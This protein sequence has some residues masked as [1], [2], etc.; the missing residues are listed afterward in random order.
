MQQPVAHALHVNRT[1][2]RPP[3][4][5]FVCRW[6][7]SKAWTQQQKQEQEDEKH[8]QKYLKN[9][10]RNLRKQRVSAIVKDQCLS[11]FIREHVSS[12]N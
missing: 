12:R 4:T 3:N 10:R 7:L 2:L 9:K 5:R 11:K 8:R 6:Y 1:W